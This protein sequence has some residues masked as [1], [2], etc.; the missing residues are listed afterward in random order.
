MITQLILPIAGIRATRNGARKG[1]GTSQVRL[2]M[3]ID[4]S[5]A[6]EIEIADCTSWAR[7]SHLS[8]FPRECESVVGIVGHV[9][10]FDGRSSLG[11]EASCGKVAMV[12]IA[13]VGSGEGIRHEKRRIRVLVASTEG[14]VRG[15]GSYRWVQGVGSRCGWKSDAGIVGRG[16]GERASGKLRRVRIG[17]GSNIVMNTVDGSCRKSK[18]VIVCGAGDDGT[19]GKVRRIQIDE[20]SKGIIAGMDCS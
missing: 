10:G 3:A 14:R 16:G 19:S 2:S 20:G 15:A 9:S 5:L 4:I 7:W 8:D 1:L 17:E 11:V 6:T 12:A 13:V 18:A